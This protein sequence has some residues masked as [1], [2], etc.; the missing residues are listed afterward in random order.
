MCDNWCTVQPL[1]P[2]HKNPYVWLKSNGRWIR[3]EE[4]LGK[5]D[6]VFKEKL[7]EK[8]KNILVSFQEEKE[9]EY[10]GLGIAKFDLTLVYPNT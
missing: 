10:T 8:K 6:T 7:L 1:H 3:K 9:M 2:S 4:K 5:E